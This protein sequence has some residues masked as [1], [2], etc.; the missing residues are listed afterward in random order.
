MKFSHDF[1]PKRRSYNIGNAEV[2]KYERTDY[3]A[4]DNPSQT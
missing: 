3:L 2:K 1:I 4:L